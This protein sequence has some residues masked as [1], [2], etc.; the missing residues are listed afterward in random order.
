MHRPRVLLARLLAEL[1][2]SEGQLEALRGALETDES[3]AEVLL[4]LARLEMEA[5]K[6]GEAQE[7]LE[8]AR[9]VV[10]DDP[11]LLLTLARLQAAQEQFVDAYGTYREVCALETPP[12]GACAERDE[13]GVK[14]GLPATPITGS[15]VRRINRNLQRLILK[16]YDEILE[17]SPGLSGTISGRVSVGEGGIPTSVEI[18]EDSLNHWRLRAL[19]YWLLMTTKFPPEKEGKALTFPFGLT[20]PEE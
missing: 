16:A 4:A 3:D 15:T 10:G 19:V 20:P 8:R 7:H 17:T 5:G 13:M 2:D 9:D 12:E 11:L 1:G 14:I 6:L 18:V